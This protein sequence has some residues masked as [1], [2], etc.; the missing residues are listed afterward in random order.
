MTGRLMN[1]SI[2]FI[3]MAFRWFSCLRRY[4]YWILSSR[5]LINGT[6]VLEGFTYLADSVDN[7]RVYN[8]ALPLLKSRTFTITEKPGRLVEIRR[9][10]GASTADSSSDGI[11]TGA[12]QILRP[13]QQVNEGKAPEF[14]ME[15]INM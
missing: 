12:L 6:N 8:R 10:A 7:V 14:L 13:G 3:L 2:S 11:N 4:I 5:Y 9:G 15:A 1:N